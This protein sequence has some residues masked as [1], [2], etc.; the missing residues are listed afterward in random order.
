ML[1]CGNVDSV[2]KEKKS[3]RLSAIITGASR[4]AAGAAVGAVAGAA[5]GKENCK[6]NVHLACSV[7]ACLFS[8]SLVLS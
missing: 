1:Y 6:P 8:P 3:L 4:G 5:A 2:R 7:Y